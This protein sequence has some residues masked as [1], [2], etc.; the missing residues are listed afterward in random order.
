MTHLIIKQ[1]DNKFAIW[2]TDIKNFV[3]LGAG[4]EEV[5]DHFIAEA[6]RK[7]KEEIIDKIIKIENEEEYYFNMSFREALDQIEEVHGK[8]ERDGVWN[9][10]RAIKE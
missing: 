6:T 3:V 8:S 1:P 7:A 4:R 10:I 5:V 2:S 9:Y